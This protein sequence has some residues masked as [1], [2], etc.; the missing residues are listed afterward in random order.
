MQTEKHFTFSLLLDVYGPLLTEKQRETLDLYVNEDLS[1]S[2]I[3]ENTGVSR[4]AAQDAIK[5][6]QQRLREW[7]K[8]LGYLEKRLR[9]EKI[10][11][12]MQS[13]RDMLEQGIEQI[14]KI[15]WEE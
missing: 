15:L 2:E 9:I 7:E 8:A 3:A 13:D 14:R 4:Q 6:A 12:R 11:Q 10:L 1:L 5:K